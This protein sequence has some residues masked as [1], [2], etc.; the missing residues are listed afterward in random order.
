MCISANANGTDVLRVMGVS[1]KRAAAKNI[2]IVNGDQLTRGH[3]SALSGASRMTMEQFCREMERDRRGGE[4][5]E[6]QRGSYVA[7]TGFNMDQRSAKSLQYAPCTYPM[8]HDEGKRKR[9]TK[10]RRKES[11]LSRSSSF[12]LRISKRPKHKPRATLVQYVL[13][14]IPCSSSPCRPAPFPRS[15]STS[16]SSVLLE[17]TQ[18]QPGVILMN[19]KY[20]KT[21]LEER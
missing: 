20:Y 16:T 19:P 11:L 10:E 2:Y 18:S 8:C 15:G 12:A 7:L 4:A 13:Y 17:E 9:V 6:K 14:T 1:Y 5:E 3:H 21:Y